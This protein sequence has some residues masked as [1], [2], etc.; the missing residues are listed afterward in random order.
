MMICN[1]QAYIP[2]VIKY[3]NAINLDNSTQYLDRLFLLLFSLGM[4]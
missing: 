3:R 2:S 4:R 1:V